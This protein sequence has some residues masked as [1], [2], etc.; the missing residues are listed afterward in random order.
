MKAYPL[1]FRMSRSLPALYTLLLCFGSL[2]SGSAQTLLQEGKIWSN[3]EYGTEQPQQ[4]IFHSYFLKVEGDTTIQ[5]RSYKKLFRSDDASHAAWTGYGFLREDTAGKVYALQVPLV[6]GSGSNEVL[7][8]DFGL[9]TGDSIEIQGGYYIKVDSVENVAY[10]GGLNKNIFLPGGNRWIEGIGSTEGLLQGIP[11]MM[12]VGEYRYLVCCSS[13]E[14]ILYKN[15]D[16][17][18]CYVEHSP[19]NEHSYHH[20][21]T[22][23]A[24]W[25]IYLLSSCSEG[26]PPMPSLMRFCLS[27]DTT[28]MDKTYHKLFL[29]KGDTAGPEITFWGGIREEDKKVYYTG[30][31][32]LGDYSY[33]VEFLLYDFSRQAG[34]T[35]EH[36]PGNEYMTSVIQSVDSVLIGSEYRKRF[37][38]E[39]NPHFHNPDEIIE[40][41]GSVRNG[42]LGGISSIPTC[43]YHYWEQVCFRENGEVVYLNPDFADCYSYEKVTPPVPYLSMFPTDTTRWNVMEEIYDFISTNSYY[44]ISD[45]LL[46]GMKFK[47]LFK[48]YLWYLLDDPI[49]QGEICGYVREN[50]TDGKTWFLDSDGDTSSMKLMMDMNLETG[51]YF[52]NVWYGNFET[53]DS[54]RVDSVFYS[55]SRKIILLTSP[56]RIPYSGKAMFIEGIGPTIGFPD[57]PV[58]EGQ[59][60]GRSLLCKFDSESRVFHSEDDWENNCFLKGGAVNNTI[61]TEWIVV[62]PNPSLGEIHIRQVYPVSGETSLVLYNASGQRLLSRRFRS[63]EEVLYLPKPGLYFVTIMNGTRALA[64][65]ILIT[66]H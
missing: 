6:D 19:V 59:F 55:G 10:A 60:L 22:T 12:M 11:G 36:W 26:M 35:I 17:L 9:D 18:N 64:K 27:G 54:L 43:G 34:D 2:I 41:I 37:F 57:V 33:G 30:P 25:N 45:T 61:S 42:L 39:S 23:N 40:G 21:P 51:D 14:E 63:E 16:F 49:S 31:G 65:K 8:Y 53:V 7:L 4:Q 29:E 5:I 56:Y 46:D 50:T 15:S 58:W 32:Y 38:V 13:G 62:F 20:F 28:L 44:S 66:G 47:I 3:L 24:N 52:N 1:S 48:K